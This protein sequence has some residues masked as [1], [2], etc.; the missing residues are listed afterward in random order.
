[1]NELEHDLATLVA[2]H[3]DL[4]GKEFVAACLRVAEGLYAPDDLPAMVFV[5]KA[6][7]EAM[8]A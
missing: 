1:M 8:G 7:D 3:S 2:K 4:S 6:L 5:G